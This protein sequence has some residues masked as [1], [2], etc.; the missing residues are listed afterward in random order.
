MRAAL[1][2]V[3]V[4]LVVVAVACAVPAPTPTV[5]VATR[6]GSF[7][8][9]AQWTTEVPT[10]WNGT[11]LLWSSGLVLPGAPNP[12]ATAP[13]ALTRAAL[14]DRGY[15]LAGSSYPPG[16]GWATD[17]LLAD[18]ERL[19]DVVAGG[20][21]RPGTTLAWGFSLGGLASAALL[22]RHPDRVAGALP[23]CGPMAGARRLTDSYLDTRA[24]LATLLGAPADDLDAL[25]AALAAAQATPP[26]RAR[27]GLAAALADLP[28]WAGA[29]TP[30]PAPADVDAQEAAQYTTLRDL[31]LPVAVATAEDLTA[32]LGGNP[33]ADAGVD[34][35]ALLRRSSGRAEVEALYDRAGLPL[36]GDL[37]A[38]DRAPRTVA[39][40][41]ARAALDRRATPPAHL[42]GPV[43]TL[44]TTGDGAVPPE[45]ERAYADAVR[46]A[47]SD[48][49]LGQLFVER[50]GH[51]MFTTA[52]LVT[53]V[54]ALAER[55]ATGRFGPLDATTAN[56]RA[57][58]LGPEM[59][60]HVDGDGP[61]PVP[62][63]F[64][65][66]TPG[67]LPR[68]DHEPVAAT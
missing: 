16:G 9:G 13:D 59:N 47:G 21:R 63:E 54:E 41:A 66:V 2:A 8:D 61:I 5:P 35:G 19:L 50:A 45:H 23:V 65:D 49:L 4:A 30:R 60:A 33:S 15:A 27:I 12:A 53:A 28:G 26:G 7:A 43:L 58:A 24:A 11:L 46:A 62:P 14:L 56:V 48:A 42:P 67:P 18:Q 36:A 52:E 10:P 22:A 64:V 38:L 68:P 39:D 29:G 37:A 40:P 51:C 25:T 31:V 32:R 3:A 20:D 44:H 17:E 1:A 34:H 55:V 57:A 6:A